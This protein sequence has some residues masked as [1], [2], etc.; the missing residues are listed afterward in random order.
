M[1]DVTVL[2]TLSTAD[3]LKE[4]RSF[5]SQGEDG[6]KSQLQIWTA[7][8][9]RILNGEEYLFDKYLIPL[10]TPLINSFAARLP[11]YGTYREDYRQEANMDIYYHLTDYNPHYNNDTYLGGAYFKG[12]LATV[13]KKF[14]RDN[15]KYSGHSSLDNDEEKWNERLYDETDDIHTSFVKEEIFHTYEK[16]KEQYTEYYARKV[17]RKWSEV[18]GYDIFS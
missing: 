10:L 13:Y 1:T 5:S 4:Y 9:E 18:K 12:R 8:K 11:E 3:F 2:F 14:K 6:I 7:L 16:N 17:T 15:E